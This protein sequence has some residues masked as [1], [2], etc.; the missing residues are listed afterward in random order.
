MTRE[1]PQPQPLPQHDRARAAHEA[2]TTG[3]RQRVPFGHG[4]LMVSFL[5]KE[6]R[7]TRPRR[8]RR[9]TRGSSLWGVVGSI[10]DPT[11]P[12]DIS[13][14]KHTYLTEASSDQHA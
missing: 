6:P 13:A 7:K 14:N 1:T 9:L 4:Y 3:R 12:T 2:A 10:D 5:T 8:A 11:G